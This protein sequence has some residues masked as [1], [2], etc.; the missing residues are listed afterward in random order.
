MSA[1]GFSRNS[2]GV[3]EVEA[4]RRNALAAWRLC[5]FTRIPVRLANTDS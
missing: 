5:S 3:V 1:G 4:T 2:P